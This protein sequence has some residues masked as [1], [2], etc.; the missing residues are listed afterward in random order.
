M[1]PVFLRIILLTGLTAFI[2][3][4]CKQQEAVVPTK[5]Q[6]NVTI[7]GEGLTRLGRQLENPYTVHTMR[8]A[9]Q[10]LKKATSNHKTATEE[11]D[12]NATHYYIKFKPQT[13]EELS[14]LKRDT[15]LSLFT[16]PLDYEVEYHGEYYH[17]P[18]VPEGQPTF[19]YASVAV[20]QLLPE[21][22][23]YELLSELFIPDDN[24][25]SP[26]TARVASAELANALVEE[27]F[28]ITGNWEEEQQTHISSA[29]ARRWRPAGRIQVWDDRAGRFVPVV[30][31]EVRAKRWFTVHKGK[32]DAQGF[33]TCDGTFDRQA[34]YSLVF[35]KY[36]FS[37]RTGTFGQAEH[38]RN[39]VTGNWNVDFGFAGNQ[40]VNNNH[41]YYALIFQAARDY[42]YGNRFG[43]ASPPQNSLVHP[44]IKIAADISQRQNDKQ[45]HA[46]NY[47]RTGGIFPSIYIREWNRDAD[48][49]YAVT[50]HELAH[51]AHWD[52]IG[53]PFKYWY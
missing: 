8:Q 34:D 14:L 23:A 49:V 15:T 27:A 5:E 47:A 16:Y 38:S 28:K 18:A 26:S 41:Q 30:D 17:D 2:S 32:T 43:L 4:A 21:G 44:Q 40:V 9:Y 3:N 29:Q 53:R 37:V 31:I 7:E 20:D 6:S 12:I 19:Q 42:Y 46:A 45:S 48:R 22:V 25:S 13:D 52:I 33:Y 1:S 36:H 11:I 50:A 51:A 35:E 24:V 10:N 39:N